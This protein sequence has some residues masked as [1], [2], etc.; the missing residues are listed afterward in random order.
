M[1]KNTTMSLAL[2][3][4]GLSAAT[5][6]SLEGMSIFAGRV[7]S[8]RHFDNS[9]TTTILVRTTAQ[10]ERSLK[11]TLVDIRM[12]KDVFEAKYGAAGLDK[13]AEVIFIA[14]DIAEHQPTRADGQKGDRFLKAIMDG[15][16]VVKPE[17]PIHRLL[18]YVAGSLAV[19]LGCKAAAIET[20]T[21]VN[22][23]AANKSLVETAVNYVSKLFGAKAEDVTEVEAPAGVDAPVA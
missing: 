14:K 21:D 5:L 10:N 2:A 22:A 20:E 9:G 3:A 15:D 17:A 6:P 7:Q 4:A 8:I 1:S 13:G 23:I 19:T 16:V 12:K 18:N 11:P